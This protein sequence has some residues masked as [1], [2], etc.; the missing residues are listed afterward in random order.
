MLDE[1]T[2]TSGDF[3]PAYAELCR[4]AI[5]Y[6]RFLCEAVGRPV[7]SHARQGAKLLVEGHFR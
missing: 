4:A 7:L 3:L 6:A 1:R 2:V 5:P